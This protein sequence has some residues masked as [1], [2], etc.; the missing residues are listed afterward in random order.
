MKTLE[1]ILAYE[2]DRRY[3]DG[4]YVIN[5]CKEAIQI[6]LIYHTDLTLY[7]LLETY[8]KRADEDPFFNTNMLFACWEMINEKRLS[9]YLEPSNIR[10]IYKV[11]NC[12]RKK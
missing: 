10:K 1:Q 5:A 11:K 6:Q 2:K 7:T 12:E 3:E 8:V 4:D 9:G